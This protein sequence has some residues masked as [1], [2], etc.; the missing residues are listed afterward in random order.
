MT[1]EFTLLGDIEAR[2][3]GQRLNI[4]HAR[5]R[6]VLAAFLIDLNHP[7]PADLL[8]ER[9]WSGKPPHHARNALAGYVSRL[10]SLFAK[11]PDAVITRES[12]G[13]VL[14]ADPLS[15]DL[16]RFRAL[17]S[18]ARAGAE[19]AEAAELFDQAMTIWSAEPFLP[20]II[21]G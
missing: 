6:S 8:V 18:Q 11:T 3:D 12:G 2:I 17:V 4:G 13:Y 7:I 1:V 10:R 19:P 20:W 15:V 5:Q 9:V 21:H 14:S 16:Y